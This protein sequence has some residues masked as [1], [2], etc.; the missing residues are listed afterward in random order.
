[1]HPGLLVSKYTAIKQLVCSHLLRALSIYT[2]IVKMPRILGKN[3]PL[4]KGRDDNRVL[5]ISGI[6]LQLSKS[7]NREAMEIAGGITS[8]F[9]VADGDVLGVQVVPPG[10]IYL[11]LTHPFL[12]AWLQNLVEGGGEEG[13]RGRGGRR[14]SREGDG[15]LFAVQYAHARCCSLLRLAVREGLIEFWE[16]E[17]DANP[18]FGSA[19]PSKPIPWLNCDE[20]LRL[21]HPAELRLIAELVQAVDNLENSDEVVSSL[22]WEKAALNLSQAFENFWSKCRIWGEVK[23]TSPE[24]AQARLGLLMA[25]QSVLRFLLEEKI[26]ISALSEL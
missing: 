8:H 26:G 1:M 16:T 15:R 22:K 3:I 24:L 19:I 2:D 6:A 11:E 9:L 12:A 7:H 25:T 10:W 21:N 18:A 17:A 5:Y 14:V 23:I 20:K 4:S 13:E